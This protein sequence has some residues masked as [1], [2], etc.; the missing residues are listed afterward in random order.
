MSLAAISAELWCVKGGNKQIPLRLLKTNKSV[1]VILNASVISI[2]TY[3][4]KNIIKYEL[5]NKT[6][7]KLYDYLIIACPLKK[8][9]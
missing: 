8:E 7:T 9:N 3:G 6:F 4:E 5:N 1:N 2:G